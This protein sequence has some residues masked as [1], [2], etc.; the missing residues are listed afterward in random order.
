VGG[1][2]E[3]EGYVSGSH[4]CGDSAG[5]LLMNSIPSPPEIVFA[6]S[7]GNQPAVRILAGSL[8]WF[9][10]RPGKNSDHLC[11][12]GVVTQTG[13][14]PEGIWPGCNCILVRFCSSFYLA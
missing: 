2:N 11:L 6:M 7:P 1:D 3:V 9:G 13:Y 12:G 10:F 8:V 4:W 14:K 5:I